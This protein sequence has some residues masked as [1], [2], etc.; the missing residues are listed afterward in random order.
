MH[1]IGSVHTW[2]LDRRLCVGNKTR[3]RCFLWIL[4]Y[5]EAHRLDRF[6][7]CTSH[8]CQ[9][10]MN[11]LQ[12]NPIKSEVTQ[13]TATRGRNEVD[14]VTSVVMSIAIVQPV[15]SIRSVGVTLDRKLSFDQHVNN[16]CSRAI[17]TTSGQ[18]GISGRRC[19]DCR[20]QCDWFPP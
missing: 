13:F 1:S 3:S 4:A 7:R 11:G 6:P 8:R 19:Q 9:L 10:Q 2:K 5:L 17:I 16:T 15:P 20:L 18:C 14:D 12:L